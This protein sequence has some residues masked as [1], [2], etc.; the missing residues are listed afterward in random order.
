M[1]CVDLL[2]VILVEH[3]Q[4]LLLIHINIKLFGIL[5]VAL[6]SYAEIF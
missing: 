3:L 2:E 4:R 5:D 6:V 1:A